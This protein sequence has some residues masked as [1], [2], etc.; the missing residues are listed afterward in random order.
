MLDHESMF[1]YEM[2]AR[3][4]NLGFVD[5]SQIAVERNVAQMINMF[6][7]ESREGY[8]NSNELTS[9][10]LAY[11]R[12]YIQSISKAFVE[13]INEKPLNEDEYEWVDLEAPKG[14]LP[15]SIMVKKTDK[16]KKEE[17]FELN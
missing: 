4:Q 3:L 5:D 11:D 17:N 10:Y 9:V 8:V 1:Y 6:I 2:Q 7:P 15:Q 16:S 13:S 14:F 12:E